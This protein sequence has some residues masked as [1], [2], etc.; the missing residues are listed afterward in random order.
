ML[1]AHRWD[2]I[3]VHWVPLRVIATVVMTCV[4]LLERQLPWQTSHVR[5]EN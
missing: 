2:M 4:V 1:C 3:S 5:E